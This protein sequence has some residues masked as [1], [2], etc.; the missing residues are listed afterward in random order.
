MARLDDLRN[1]EIYMNGKLY[2]SGI[3]SYDGAFTNSIDYVNLGKHTPQGIWTG[4]FN[5][6]MDEVYIYNRALNLCEIE[7]L[8][9]GQLLEER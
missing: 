8:Y 3:F 2:C 9:S 4:A 7:A 1:A 5:G 6:I